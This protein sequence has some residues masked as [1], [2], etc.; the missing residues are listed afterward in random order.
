MFTHETYASWTMLSVCIVLWQEKA[1]APLQPKK[2]N[3]KKET[4]DT[5][6]K[7]ESNFKKKQNKEDTMVSKSCSSLTIS[8]YYWEHKWITSM[9]VKA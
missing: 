7:L 8:I 5:S 1:V 9:L 2:R 3:I 6:R 4:T